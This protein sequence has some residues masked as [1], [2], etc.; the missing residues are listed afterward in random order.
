MTTPAITPLHR[1]ITLAGVRR[2]ETANG[3]RVHEQASVAAALEREWTYDAYVVA[4]RLERDGRPLRNGP[5][6]KKDSLARVREHGIDVLCGVRIADIDTQPKRPLTADDIAKIG[7]VLSSY[8]CCWYATKNGARI[9]QPLTRDLSPE[10]LEVS[11]RRWLGELA[12]IVASMDVQGLGVDTGCRDWTRLMRLPRVVRCDFVDAKPRYTNLWA[13]PLQGLDCEAVDPGDCTPPP[14]VERV[15]APR[16]SAD[17]SSPYGLAALERECERM[18]S[19]KDGE[20]NN[21]LASAAFNLGGLVAS[22]HLDRGEALD[23]LRRAIAARGYDADDYERTLQRCLANGEREP[24]GPDPTQRREAK[25][26]NLDMPGC[27]VTD[28]HDEKA[29]RRLLG[30]VWGKPKESLL[31]YEWE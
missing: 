24:R 10:E 14:K 30:R 25:P 21:T 29:L 7:H 26:L 4:Y 22:G 31:E 11:L 16:R 1:I 6:L 23:G 3:K 5:R 9:I 28:Y 20:G 15:E 12:G 27:G 13:T 8:P 19:A 18:A 17:Q 2:F